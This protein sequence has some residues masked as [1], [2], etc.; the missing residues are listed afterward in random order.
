MKAGKVLVMRAESRLEAVS[1]TSPGAAFILIS[2][3]GRN[4][5]ES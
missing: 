3:G 1:F 2:R 4:G 5:T